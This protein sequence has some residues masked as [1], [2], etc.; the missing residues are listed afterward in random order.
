MY[1]SV[2]SITKQED[3]FEQR[4]I[5]AICESYRTVVYQSIFGHI[6]TP[7]FILV[8]WNLCSLPVGQID[9]CERS[10]AVC[11]LVTLFRN[12]DGGFIHIITGECLLICA[13][14]ATFSFANG[15]IFV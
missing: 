15:L 12:R 4:K 9:G 3:D 6:M 2:Y 13:I 10:E 14:L 11:L 8:M 7:I 1:S 5:R